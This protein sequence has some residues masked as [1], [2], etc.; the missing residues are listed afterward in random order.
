MSDSLSLLVVRLAARPTAMPVGVR[1]GAAVDTAAFLARVRAWRALLREQAG[2]RW[3]LYLEDS[4]E[5]AA[6]LL[7]AWHAGKTV[8][9]SADTLDATCAHL[10]R[11]VDGFLGDFPAARAPLAPDPLPQFCPGDDAPFEALDDE[12]DALVVFTSGSTGAAQAIPKKLCQ[13][14]SEVATLEMLFGA[15]AGDAHVIATVSHQHIYG[16]LFKVLWPLYTGRTIHAHSIAYPETLAAALAAQPAV[17]VASPAHLKRL[18]AHLDWSGARTQLRAVFSSGGPLPAD[19]AQACGTLLGAVPFEVFGSSETGG[20]AWRR[21]AQLPQVGDE[22]WTP[23]PTVTW[24][25][26]DGLLEVRSPHLPDDAWLRLADRAQELAGGRFQLMGRGD[27][28][29]KIEEKRI[30]LDALEAAL[31]ATDLAAEARV[32][33]CDPEPGQRQMLAAFVVPTPAGRAL[34]AADGKLA[35][36]GRLR[37]ALAG[38]VDAVALPRRWR[39]L[40]Q[41]P[42][43]AQGKTTVAALLALLSDPVR[44]PHVQVLERDERRVLIEVTAPVNLLYFD[45]HFDQAPILPGVAQVEWAIRYGREHFAL[46]PAFRTMQALKFQH[47]IQPGMPVQLELLHDPAKGQLTFAYRSSAGQHASGRVLFGEAAD[48]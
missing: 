10:A 5:F 24:R 29:A 45:G 40:D 34:L 36:N 23:F 17:L 46:P 7:G 31:L 26:V 41:L 9:L 8:W 6:A 13:L 38:V 25:L 14:A 30:S 18:P 48:V 20:I 19:T 21:R 27:R 15:A 47:V 39:Y 16:L 44:Q 33:L 43:N 42:V 35:L 32:V 3:A 22:G 37:A 12:A 1:D 4:I 2:T 28:I 11:E